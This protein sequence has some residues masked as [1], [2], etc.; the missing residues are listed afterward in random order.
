MRD[1]KQEEFIPKSKK[2]NSLFLRPQE[3]TLFESLVELYYATMDVKDFEEVHIVP[4]LKEWADLL[5][6]SHGFTPDLVVGDKTLKKQDFEERK[7]SCIHLVTAGKDSTSTA[8]KFESEFKDKN[9]LLHVQGVNK[10]YPTEHRMCKKLYKK[11]MPNSPYNQIKAPMPR[12]SGASESPL[13][14][15]FIVVLA[16]EHFGFIPRYI[17]LGGSAGI[18]DVSEVEVFGDSGRGIRPFLEALNNSYGS[19]MEFTPYL[20]D[21]VEAYE[22]CEKHKIDYADLASCMSQLRFKSKQR[23]MAID[24]YSRRVGE[25]TLIAGTVKESGLSIFKVPQATLDNL[26][27]DNIDKYDEVY[28][29]DYR[30]IGGCFKCREK[31]IVYNHHF[32]Y[33]YHPEYMKKCRK[34]IVDW[35]DKSPNNNGVKLEQYFDTVLGMPLSTIPK[36]YHAYIAGEAKRP[37]GWKPPLKRHAEFSLDKVTWKKLTD[38]QIKEQ[39]KG[40]QAPKTGSKI[41]P[42]PDGKGFYKIWKDVA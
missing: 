11:A 14:N 6:E 41:F 32:G 39:C 19:S 3:H 15:M 9:Y 27:L 8:L 30:C 1:I 42:K 28:P 17:T 18:A 2:R 10:M 31:A 24:K 29:D 5:Y 21:Q 25:H 23:S 26:T 37:D 16:I 22:I 34:G 12:V 7:D 4:Q 33:E 20:R 35:M 38:K 13:K 40:M 36:K